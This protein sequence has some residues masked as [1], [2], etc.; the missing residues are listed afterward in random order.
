VKTRRNDL[1]PGSKLATWLLLFAILIGL[2][3]ACSKGAPAGTSPATTAIPVGTETIIPLPSDTPESPTPTSE[4]LVATV[5]GEG[6]SLSVFDAELARYQAAHPG[7]E[8]GQAER[9][10]VLDSLVDTRLLAQG[11]QEAGFQLSEQD[12]QSRL[13]N[14]IEQAGGA[15]AFQG[16]LAQNDYDKVS[17]QQ[18]LA[19]NAAA[20]WMRDQ[21]AAQVPGTAEQVHARQIFLY[22]SEDAKNVLDR[23]NAG[24]DFV[25]IAT[26]VD[27][28]AAGELGWFP[29]GYLLEPEI[30]AA[31][32]DLQAGEYS[33]VIE[34]RL[35]YH[36]L[37]VIERQADRPLEPDA[38]RVLQHKAVQDWLQERRT[39]STVE[40]HLP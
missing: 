36:I 29:R 21:I 34:T 32:F 23:L 3:S 24:T 14:L 17:F 12:L 7:V 22:N 35:G 28:V 39:V 16:W 26:E 2:L 5:N 1:K 37:Q 20:A 19:L 27:P 8:I 4:P 18:D 9:Q 33:Q 15:E 30:E 38:L 10:L 31:A 11:A 25:T 40:V 6:I 13:D